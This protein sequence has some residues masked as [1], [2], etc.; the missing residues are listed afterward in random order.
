MAG[1]K[2]EGE[3]SWETLLKIQ[4]E[5]G[6]FTSELLFCY[7]SRIERN[8]SILKTYN[9]EKDIDLCYHII[10]LLQEEAENILKKRDY[11]TDLE[12]LKSIRNYDPETMCL[13]GKAVEEAEE[14]DLPDADIQ[15]M[16]AKQVLISANN[17]KEMIETN[18]G[19]N[20]FIETVKLL[21][22]AVTASAQ[23]Y[24]WLGIQNAIGEG[25]SHTKGKLRGVLLAIEDIRLRNPLLRNKRLPIWN[26]LKKL[27]KQGTPWNLTKDGIRYE[28][29]FSGK[30]T[31]IH[32]EFSKKGEASEKELSKQ[33]FKIHYFKP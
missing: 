2:I 11:P 31:L 17:L 16:N 26:H 9:K 10:N 15:I 27:E 7:P 32:K 19:Q 24:A 3:Y 22:S 5:I 33:T 29:S 18:Q 1:K 4:R 12:S 30:D 13:A 14:D 21:A 20:I 23:Y 28:I 25:K 8:L 6:H